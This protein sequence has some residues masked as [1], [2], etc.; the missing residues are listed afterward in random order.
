MSASLRQGAAGSSDT[1]CRAR[2]APRGPPL[3]RRN[4]HGTMSASP[5]PE[6]VP[7]WTE[8][9]RDLRHAGGRLSPP[10]S[11][12]SSPSRRRSAPPRRRAGIRSGRSVLSGRRAIPGTTCG[13][14]GLDIGYR[15]GHGHSHGHAVITA[16]AEKKLSCFNLDLDGLK[17]SSVNVNGRSASYARSGGELTVHPKSKLKKGLPFV[18]IVSYSGVPESLDGAGFLAHR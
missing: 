7:S 10:R 18:V 5:A 12:S 6:G 14:Y 17:V 13:H 9:H 15:A 8:E 1:G 3:T 16:T 2:R 11:R 4:P